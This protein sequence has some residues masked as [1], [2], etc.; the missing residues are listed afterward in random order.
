MHQWFDVQL[1]QKTLD[2][3]FSTTSTLKSC[4]IQM[5]KIAEKAHITNL[6]LGVSV[7]KFEFDGFNASIWVPWSPSD[8]KKYD[9]L[10]EVFK[11][12]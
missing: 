12:I 7:I 5:A 8:Q 9:A 2:G 4:A 1:D 6:T 10:I 3:L 11:F